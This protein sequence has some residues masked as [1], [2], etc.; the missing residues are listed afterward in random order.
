MSALPRRSHQKRP[1]PSTLEHLL[2][3]QA[4]YELGN[5][6]FASV[7]TKITNS[8]LFAQEYCPALSSKDACQKIY[9]TVMNDSGFDVAAGFPQ[10]QKPKGL[11]ESTLL[12]SLKPS[13]TNTRLSER[14][15]SNRSQ[16]L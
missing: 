6:S 2:I 13:L 12:T 16:I 9:N 5:T 7:W 3:F 14:A 11:I 1:P 10:G 4:V 8:S 15:L